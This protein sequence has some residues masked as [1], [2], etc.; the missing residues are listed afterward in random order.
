MKPKFISFVPAIFWFIVTIVLMTLPASDIPSSSFLDEIYIDKWVH[1]GM[2]S[3]LVFLTSFP[4]YKKRY[5]SSVYFKITLAAIVYG[6]AMEF[7]QRYFTEGRSFD[8][9]D[10]VADAA[11][12]FIGFIFIK[13][14]IRRRVAAGKYN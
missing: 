11:G 12:A 6:V 9:W 1:I 7:V 13:W 2:F 14:I 5:S 4:F 8:V 3:I 10:M